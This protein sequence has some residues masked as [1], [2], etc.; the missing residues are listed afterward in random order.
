[1]SGN[2]AP[3]S[4]GA[5][6]DPGPETTQQRSLVKVHP[7]RFTSDALRARQLL[8]APDYA[9]LDATGKAADCVDVPRHA[10]AVRATYQRV[11]AALV[12]Q[13]ARGGCRG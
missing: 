9:A 2:E 8:R 6:T 7:R 11:K 12:F 3:G 10:R 5:P 4:S 1:M 13:R